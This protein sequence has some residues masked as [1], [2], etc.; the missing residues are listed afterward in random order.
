MSGGHGKAAGNSR[1]VRYNVRGKRS[2]NV[3]WCNRTRK[4]K[5]KAGSCAG[6]G[7]EQGGLWKW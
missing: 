2:A 6:V 1:G 3:T 5:W 7:L 4:G